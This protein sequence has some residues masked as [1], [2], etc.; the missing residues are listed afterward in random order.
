VK[1]L[2][3]LFFISKVCI[4]Y[5][6]NNFLQAFSNQEVEAAKKRMNRLQEVQNLVD[7]TWK[8]SRW[9]MDVLSYA[10]DKAC[11]PG[12]LS[13]SVVLSRHRSTPI[14][15][16]TSALIP[17]MAPSLLTSTVAPYHSPEA[18]ARHLAVGLMRQRNNHNNNGGGGK[19]EGGG[20]PPAL[21]PK[22]ATIAADMVSMAAALPPP[23]ANPIQ[24][25]ASAASIMVSLELKKH[26]LTLAGLHEFVFEARD[27]LF[28]VVP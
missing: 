6:F 17:T 11:P 1:P 22:P 2:N 9:I 8:G 16:D 27:Q 4:V 14:T 18:A 19:Q 26:S 5:Y 12:S 15:A 7:N 25:V 10:R 28:F 23:T 3:K 21:P 20:K 24:L 13:A